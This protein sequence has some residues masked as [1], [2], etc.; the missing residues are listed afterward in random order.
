MRVRECIAAVSEAWSGPWRRRF[1]HN[2]ADAEDAV[3]RIFVEMWR[4][5][6][7]YDP[8]IA[9]EVTF[10]RRHRSPG[11]DRRAKQTLRRRRT[12]SVVERYAGTVLAQ[13]PLVE[14]REE[15]QRALRSI[16]R[17]GTRE[18]LVISL[19]IDRGLSH[20]CIATVTGLP[21]GTVKTHARRGLLKLTRDV[22][23]TAG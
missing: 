16:S 14:R 2:H 5:A 11:T 15:A 22:D 8:T 9:A 7:R 18:Q 4:S 12:L 19:S 21:V 23:I 3:Q 20:R 13:D 1:C 6:A 17:L 10:V